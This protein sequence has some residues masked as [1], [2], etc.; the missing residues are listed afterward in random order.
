[1]HD[2]ELL[3]E[4]YNDYMED[5]EI[6][7][8]YGSEL[9]MSAI[10]IQAS[11]LIDKI[12]NE[13]LDLF[14]MDLENNKAYLSIIS[15]SMP[16]LEN[17]YPEYITRYSSDTNMIIDSPEYKIEQLS[18]SHLNPFFNIGI[19]NLTPSIAWTKYTNLVNSYS[20]SN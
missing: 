5:K 12:Y 16:L 9:L 17:H 11:N 14:I 20:D 2:T 4:I 13:C 1:V 3:D 7:L 10:R 18:T 19:I 6:F 15:K 8:K